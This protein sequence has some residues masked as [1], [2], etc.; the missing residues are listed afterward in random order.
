[1]SDPDCICD[2]MLMPCDSCGEPYPC[3]VHP[4]GANAIRYRLEA[5][6]RKRKYKQLQIETA[7]RLEKLE[8]WM[9][10]WLYRRGAEA[11]RNGVD[12][13]AS[14]LDQIAAAIHHAIGDESDDHNHL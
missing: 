11:M 2:K 4:P 1:M 14:D 9:V 12:G 5:L 10:D 6:G 13:V 7:E 3:P 8:P